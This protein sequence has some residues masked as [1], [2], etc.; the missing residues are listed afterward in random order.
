MT[1][2]DE[3]DRAAQVSSEAGQ[4]P[5]WRDELRRRALGLGADAAAV[6]APDQVVTAEWVR[7]KCL[8][9]GCT[10][11]RCLTCPPHSPAPAQMRAVLDEYEAVLALR[12]DAHP[13]RGDQYAALS[14]RAMDVALRLE[15][16]LFLAGHH[17]AF[18]IAGGRPCARDEACGDPASCD[19]RELVR[20]GPAGCGIDVFT[21][22]ANAGWP[23][24]VVRTPLDSYHR[25]SLV[26]V[27]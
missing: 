11:G 4:G 3:A 23:L 5:A 12:F 21:T 7:L 8:Y 9:G 26:L 13:K 15:R 24:A 22:S 20:P 25:L 18:A 27:R 14:H 17:K 2:H 16:E 1:A 6:I 10:V 19:C